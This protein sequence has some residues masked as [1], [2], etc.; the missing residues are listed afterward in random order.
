MWRE[1]MN[2]NN[3][4]ENKYVATVG[5]LIEHLQKFDKNAKLCFWDEGGAHMECVHILKDM[6]GDMMFKTVAADKAYRKKTFGDS[7]KQLEEDFAYVD[8]ADMIVY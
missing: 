5:D 6:L 1:T 7:D 8:D 3:I 2:K 4:D